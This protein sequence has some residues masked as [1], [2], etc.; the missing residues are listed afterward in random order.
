MET[1]LEASAQ[2]MPPVPAAVDHAAAVRVPPVQV[3]VVYL[4]ILI[5]WAQLAS[6]AAHLL[7][8]VCVYVFTS[9]G[10][11]VSWVAETTVV[12]TTSS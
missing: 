3:T 7:L 1:V 10:L 4:G 2:R 8:V 12:T 11:T 9:D 5:I 6:A